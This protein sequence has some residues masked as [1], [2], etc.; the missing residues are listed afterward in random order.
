MIYK[1]KL[2]I[3]ITLLSIIHQPNSSAE[4]TW[5]QKL[6]AAL[7]HPLTFLSGSLLSIGTY[8]WY[9]QTEQ[10][11]AFSWVK[12]QWQ[13]KPNL[14]KWPAIV[15]SGCFFYYFVYYKVMELPNNKELYSLMENNADRTKNIETILQL[16][17]T[18]KAPQSSIAILQVKVSNL[19]AQSNHFNSDT[20]SSSSEM[21]SES[22]IDLTENV[23][24]II[25]LM[26]RLI[27]QSNQSEI[28]IKSLE[29]DVK[30]AKS[31]IANL[32]RSQK[33]KEI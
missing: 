15:F 30:N 27:A 14:I 16:P 6:P 29:I 31:L 9:N 18:S 11:E 22:I 24:N 13:T 2:F 25:D 26:P 20:Q 23:N 33:P 1:K 10:A 19:E 28:K 32:V 4:K 7:C 5:Y 21:A 3:I 17:P 12:E 8:A